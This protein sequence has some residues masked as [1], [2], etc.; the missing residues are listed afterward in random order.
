[1]LDFNSKVPLKDAQNTIPVVAQKPAPAPNSLEAL[2]AEI[3]EMENEPMAGSVS[4][5]ETMPTEGLDKAVAN[6]E[7]RMSQKSETAP[8]IRKTVPKKKVA[9]APKHLIEVEKPQLQELD[10]NTF[11]TEDSE[12]LA[13]NMDSPLEGLITTAFDETSHSETFSADSMT[14]QTQP[15]TDWVFENK[16]P[17]EVRFSVVVG[18]YQRNN[19]DEIKAITESAKTE[20][21]KILQMSPAPVAETSPAPSPAK[22]TIEAAATL[23]PASDAAQPANL[24]PI[25]TPAPKEAEEV[26]SSPQ[27]FD[28]DEEITDTRQ[29]N[30]KS[31]AEYDPEAEE[32]ATKPLPE[33]VIP[34]VPT[35]V[36]RNLHAAP[37]PLVGAMVGTQIA[38]NQIKQNSVNT[39]SAPKILVI[40]PSAADEKNC[41]QILAMQSQTM[42]KVAQENLKRC[43]EELVKRKNLPPPAVVN[44]G[45]TNEVMYGEL[46]ID[47]LM[48]D[49]L[50]THKGHIELYLQPVGSHEPQD[51]VFL[52]YQYPAVEFQ[53]E[54][55]I[56]SNSY[57]LYAGIY[58]PDVPTAVA[59]IRYKKSISAADYKEIIPFT[60]RYSDLMQ[61]LSF[62]TNGAP[63]KVVLSI[64]LFEGIT[65]NSKH[66]K[67]IPGASVQIVGLPSW[68]I[69]TSDSDG[70]VRIPNAPANSE[71]YLDIRA[72]GYYNTQTIVPTSTTN[73]YR[74][75]YLVSKETVNDITKYFTKNQQKEGRGVIIGRVFGDD[76]APE[77]DVEVSLSA[78]RGKALYIDALP[79]IFANST[80]ATGLFGFFNVVPSFRSITTSVAQHSILLGVKPDSA[81]YVE[82]GRG[83]KRNL[84]G[85]LMDPFEGQIPIA[86]VSLVGDS[87]KEIYTDEKGNFSIPNINFPPGVL[88]LDVEAESYPK[89]RYTIPWN[90]REPEKTRKFYMVQSDLIKESITAHQSISRDKA[91]VVGGAEPNMFA[92]GDRCILVT[93]KYTDGNA[94]PPE[95]GPFPLV[96][97]DRP[98]N[99]P[100]CL[101]KDKPGFVFSGVDPGGLIVLLEGTDN[102]PR[103]IS[104][105]NNGVNTTSILVF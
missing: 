70:N 29:A 26:T 18:E 91:I 35:L 68:G 100:L 90:T 77:K 25:E 96:P 80:S 69:F 44:A 6:L 101:T 79:N 41:A 97:L 92:N 19:F 36:N 24:E 73:F 53:I 83:G 2:K 7:D 9:A 33:L 93:A 13:V 82:L 42:T 10:W 94:L 99:G 56:M 95:K 105:L 62:A 61:N 67:P 76:R 51:T 64:T 74:S 16:Y 21:S 59:Q 4:E 65:G 102:S 55:K 20:T 15:D 63:S 78:R 23:S 27:K 14:S 30:Y 52:P 3:K 45:P 103:K 88:S 50:N 46:D 89:I 48:T 17:R 5:E 72:N 12:I 11:E 47:P 98:S 31:N 1:M 84:V 87:E 86:K 22:P 57:W 37:T 66:P 49:W 71:L 39:P 60:L 58:V 85:Q 75:L 40:K 81:Q 32:Q 34:T 54:T 104:Y 43:A 38:T 8:K 28:P